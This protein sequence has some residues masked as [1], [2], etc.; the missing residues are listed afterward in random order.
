[1]KSQKPKI[2]DQEANKEF[3]LKAESLNYNPN[4]K[5]VGGYVE[6]EWDHSR[7]IFERTEL[8][9]QNKNVLEV[10]CNMGAT[11]IILSLL[12]AKVTAIDVNNEY[13]ELAKLNAKRYG[14]N[15][16]DFIL[17]KNSKNLNFS[18]NYFDYISCNSVLEY[19]PHF[20][21]KETITEIDRLLKS[22]GI[23][24]I[25]GTSNRLSPIEVHSRKWFINYLPRYFDPIFFKT[26][27]PERGIS[28]F[29]ILKQLPNY[30]N[31]DALDNNRTYM[32]TQNKI[33][34]SKIKSFLLKNIGFFTLFF[35]FSIGMFTPNIFLALKKTK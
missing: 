15:N 14:V 30:I 26:K 32:Q 2:L 16:I 7:H 33:G 31:I 4:D 5:W 25:M 29:T 3:F 21:L 10:G 9:L 18:D 34:C 13:I 8:D 6:Y 28:P 20:E 22:D 27:T 23:L 1:M 24:Y 12:G 11:S 19:V 17:V 35:K